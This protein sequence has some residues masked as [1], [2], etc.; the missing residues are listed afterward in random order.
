MNS[1]GTGP[2]SNM[3][4]YTTTSM[5]MPDHMHPPTTAALTAPTNVMAM[6]DAAGALTLTWQGAANAES[7]ILIAVHS[8]NFTYERTDVSDGAARSGTVTGLTP[9][10]DYIGI[11]VALKGSGDDLEVVHGSSSV[12]PVQ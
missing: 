6:S 12:T 2:W 5:T 7:Y 4:Y 8:T 9:D 3:A 10:A 11:V 1:V